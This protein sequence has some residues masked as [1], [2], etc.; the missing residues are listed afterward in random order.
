[1]VIIKYRSIFLSIAALMVLV[2][3]GAI[4][5]Y[6]L[7]LGID[8]TGGAILE[9]EYPAARPNLEI[10]QAELVKRAPAG[11]GRP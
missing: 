3:W 4:A 11:I 6:G 2:S 8:F 9:L 1:M 5:Y 10:V 7:N